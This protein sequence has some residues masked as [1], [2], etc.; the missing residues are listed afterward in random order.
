ML[1]KIMQLT[2]QAIL[3]EKESKD[4]YFTALDLSQIPEWN[5][6]DKDAVKINSSV[7]ATRLTGY[8]AERHKHQCGRHVEVV[9]VCDECR[10][11]N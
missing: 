9:W 4:Y 1:E 8:N 10:S 6:T 11:M 5:G 3:K 2:I 7:K